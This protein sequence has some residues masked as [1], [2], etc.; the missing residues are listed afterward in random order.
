MGNKTSKEEKR[1]LKRLKKAEA[2]EQ[3]QLL[4]Q[5]KIASKRE[6][7]ELKVKGKQESELG[8]PTLSEAFSRKEVKPLST[9]NEPLVAVNN[10]AIE[11]NSA[12]PFDTVNETAYPTCGQGEEVVMGELQSAE[13]KL[14]DKYHAEEASSTKKEKLQQKKKRQEEKKNERAEKEHKAIA[15]SEQQNKRLIKQRDKR[16][17]KQKALELEQVRERWYKLDNSALIYPAI[18]NDEWNSVFRI[19]AIMKERVDPIKLQEALDLTIDRFP[20]FNVSLKDG[21]FW[22]FFQALTEKPKIEKETESP[23]RPFIFKKNAHILRVLYYDRKISFEIFHSL[24]DGGGAMQFFN[25]LIVAY[26]ELTGVKVENKSEYGLSVYDKP[27]IEEGEDS[28]KRY[29]QKDTVRSRAE[30]KAYEI[31]AEILE[32]VY[33]RVFNANASVK[34]IKEVAKTYGATINEFLSAIYLKTLIEHKHLYDR[35]GKKPVKLSVPVNIRKHLPSK[36]MR[37][38]ALVLNIEVPLEKENSTIE[39]LIGI[40]KEQ[41][42]NLN[43]EYVLGFIGKNVQSERNFLVRILPLFIKKP[44]MRLVYSQVGETL[45]TSTLTN[46]GMIKLPENALNCIESYQCVLGAT[47]LNKINLAVVSV[48]DTIA[49]TLSSRLKENSLARNFYKTLADCGVELCIQSNN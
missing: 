10:K 19:S 17:K 33:L 24:S 12:T 28:F 43:E 30:Q 38:F 5:Q 41:M 22:P 36:T 9:E 23:C 7:K 25:V 42:N 31:K 40:I 21:L 34:Q 39:E 2:K 26:I 3:K 49:I 1:D 35:N 47:K 45:F 32:N 8:T 48:G 27:I 11:S 16:I 20:F 44:I 14:I 13:S 15:E 18:C 29:A 4:K 37:N 46:V 6:K